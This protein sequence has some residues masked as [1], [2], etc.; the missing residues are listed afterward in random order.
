MV[1]WAKMS[2]SNDFPYVEFITLSYAKIFDSPHAEP[3]VDYVFADNRIYVK[4]RN[5]KIIPLSN[6]GQRRD[7]PIRFRFN[8]NEGELTFNRGLMEN[9]L[10]LLFDGENIKII[11]KKWFTNQRIPF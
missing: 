7:G 4:S 11:D 8:S 3:G 5:V 2:E 9:E 1:A 6:S 10:L